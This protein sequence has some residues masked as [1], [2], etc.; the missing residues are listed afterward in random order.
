LLVDRAIRKILSMPPEERTRAEELLSTLYALV[1]HEREEC[2]RHPLLDRIEAATWK[3]EHRQELNRIG[4]TIAEALREEG[5]AEERVDSA[6]STLLRQFRRK[7]GDISQDVAERIEGTTDLE[8]LTTWLDQI[9][10][11]ETLEEM[12]IGLEES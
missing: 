2:E 10:T 5:R 12:G 7:F 3:P 8:R 11:V 9:V 4:R 1:Y 6:R